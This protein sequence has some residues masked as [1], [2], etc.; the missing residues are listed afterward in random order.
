MDTRTSKTRPWRKAATLQVHC[1]SMRFQTCQENQTGILSLDD[2]SELEPESTTLH[3]SNKETA[4]ATRAQK[5]GSGATSSDREED[6]PSSSSYENES[7]NEDENENEDA[8]MEVEYDLHGAGRRPFFFRYL[9]RLVRFDDAPIDA[10]GCSTDMFARSTVFMASIFLGPALLELAS[11]EAQQI[12]RNENEDDCENARVYGFK[13]SSLLSNIAIAGYLVSTIFLPIFGAIVDHTP[14]RRH[15]GA[16]TAFGLTFIKAL[17]TIFLSEWFFIAVLQTCSLIFFQLHVVAAYAY[18]A[19]LSSAPNTQSRYQTHF[20]TSM[21][22]S[23]T[24]YMLEV[25]IPGT[26][27][28]LDDVATARWAVIVTTVTSVPLFFLAWRYLFRDCPPIRQVL[29]GRS[30]WTTGFAQLRRTHDLLTRDRPAV[31]TFLRTM[32]FSEAANAA[33]ATIAT[34][35]MSEF[36]Q[37]SGLE[38]GLTILIVLIFGLPGSWLGHYCTQRYDPVE[39]TKLCLIVYALNTAAACVTLEP[40]RKN[41]AYVYGAVWGICQGWIHPQHTTIFVTITVGGGEQQSTTSS[42]AAGEDAHHHPSTI[43]PSSSSSSQQGVVELMG[44]F[45]FACQ[46]LSFLPPLV[47][48]ALNEA[49]FSMQWGLASLVVYFVIG[50]WGLIQMGDYRSAID[51]VNTPLQHHDHDHDQNGNNNGITSH[52]ATDNVKVNLGAGGVL[53]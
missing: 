42:A 10:T 25:L 19:E 24:L 52:N 36:L 16:W 53:T 5:R 3:E 14:Y 22:I 15:V 7:E 6:L 32:A 50:Y 12:C 33:L 28:G 21:F 11:D 47:F 34:T 17:E 18:S 20:F 30:L 13:P 27:L 41:L 49:G 40:E 46:I 9:P 1:L 45:L 2:P 43:I 31:A 39:S 44:V 23:M 48:T 4:F 29:P 8:V 38:I 37:M 35:Y 26:I 51:Q